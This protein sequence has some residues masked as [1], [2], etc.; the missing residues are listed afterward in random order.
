[1]FRAGYHV[2]PRT[3]NPSHGHVGWAIAEV[4]VD[5]RDVAEVDTTAR[6]LIDRHGWDITDV[7]FME[8][9]RLEEWEGNLPA[10]AVI[11]QAL[12]EGAAVRYLEVPVGGHRHGA[13]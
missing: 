7:L 5:Q 9:A 13:A 3:T 12:S 4:F 1:M 2:V 6:Q 10:L 11:K 8:E